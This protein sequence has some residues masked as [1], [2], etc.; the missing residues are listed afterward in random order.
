MQHVMAWRARLPR[1]IKWLLGNPTRV[2]MLA[3]LVGIFVVGS[4][5]LARADDLIPGPD[6]TGGGPKTL[7]ETHGFL[8]YKLPVKPDDDHS[9]WFDI[10]ETVLEV[11]GFVN[12]LILWMALAPLRGGLVLLEWFLNLTVYRDSAGQ[13]DVAVQHVATHVFWPLISAT[14]A[15]GAFISYA[16]WRN[17][18][19][20]FMGDMAWLVAAIAL[21]MAFAAGPS[22]VMRSVDSVRQDLASNIITA[23]TTYIGT[24]ENPTGF[25]NPQLTGDPQRVASRRLVDGVW[26]SFGAVPWCIAAFRTLEICKKVGHHALANDDTWRRMMKTLDDEGVVPEFGEHASF[27][28]GQDMTRTGVV[29]LVA[30]IAIP[31]ALLLLR[32]IIAG[33]VTTSGFMLMLVIGLLFL[34]FWP[35]PGWFRQT[36]LRYLAYTVGLQ[37]QSLF[38]TTV[39]SGVAVVSSILSLLIGQYGVLLVSVLNIALLIAASKVRSW[40]E[41]LTS[42][43]GAGSMGYM[44][45]MLASGAGRFAG[46]L[47]GRAVGTGLGLAAKTATGGVGRIG[48]VASSAAGRVLSNLRAE[49]TSGRPRY[50]EIASESWKAVKQP[51]EG[52][53]PPS[54][55]TRPFVTLGSKSWRALTGRSPATRGA[56]G[57]PSGRGKT[58]A[59]R[60]SRPAAGTGRPGGSRT[61]GSLPWQRKLSPLDSFLPRSATTRGRTP[62]GTTPTSTSVPPRRQPPP[63][64]GKTTP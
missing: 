49:G 37:F 6:L 18:G 4:V 46:R 53:G 41:T 38:L 55:I 2:L 56:S 27:I 35:I 22:S 5:D 54:A 34:T 23:N 31:M 20:G 14:A 62:R 39:I 9:G 57:A 59:G 44:G 8:N 47:A 11:I 7:Y 28:R 16:R 25:P 24:N 3:W 10:N 60:R 45:A 26:G 30:L 61:P 21:A 52:M 42:V 12:N 43:G 19:R 64:P 15:V 1:P 32:L 36:G 51:F 63:P 48:S 29:I 33:L 17:D 58:S 13:I 50:K 40:L